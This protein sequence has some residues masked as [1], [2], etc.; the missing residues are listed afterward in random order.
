M[1]HNEKF[2]KSILIWLLIPLSILGFGAWHLLGLLPSFDEDEVRK[3]GIA[4]P[5][6][7]LSVQQTNTKINMLWVYDL[8]LEIHPKAE[9][10]FQAAIS[11]TFDNV[12]IQSLRR[13]AWVEVRYDPEERQN[14]VLMA[15]G[16]TSPEARSVAHKTNT[17]D[18]GANSTTNTFDFKNTKSIEVVTKRLKKYLKSGCKRVIRPPFLQQGKAESTVDLLRKGSSCPVAV[19]STGVDG[20]LLKITMRSPLN[21]IMKSPPDASTIAIAECPEIDGEH[22]LTIEASKGTYFAI[23]VISCPKKVIKRLKLQ[24]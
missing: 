23:G 13:G 22:R 16:A 14:V 1:T 7:I 17:A 2:D 18:V 3:N 21:E 24:K 8:A 20:S 10:P 6:K 12:Q 4:A 5:A 9:E 11:D 19:A 15:T